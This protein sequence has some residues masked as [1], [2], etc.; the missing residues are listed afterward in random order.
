VAK[1]CVFLDREGVLRTYRR[2]GTVIAE[3]CPSRAASSS[4]QLLTRALE[5]LLGEAEHLGVGEKELAGL[6]KQALQSRRV[7]ARRTRR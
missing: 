6:F 7:T 5:R 4:G 2:R 3:S 1:A